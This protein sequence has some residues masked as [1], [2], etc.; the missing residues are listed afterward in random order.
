MKLEKAINALM[1]LGIIIS[2]VCTILIQLRDNP[3]LRNSKINDYKSGS[4]KK[5]MI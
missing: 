2:G 1:T 5:E 3:I 4:G